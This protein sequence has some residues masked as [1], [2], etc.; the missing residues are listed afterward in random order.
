[1][2]VDRL[3]LALLAASITGIVWMAA[4]SPAPA[5]PPGGEVVVA[6]DTGCTLLAAPP[7]P[8]TP[9]CSTNG[10]APEAMQGPFGSLGDAAGGELDVKAMAGVAPFDELTVLRIGDGTPDL[11]SHDRL[12]LAIRVGGLWYTRDLASIGP[13]CGGMGHPT[14]VDAEA[15]AP[16]IVDGAVS[17]RVRETYRQ[18]DSERTADTLVECR[19]DP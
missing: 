2:L 11:S 8:P 1:M 3:D 16:R 7:R 18:G 6:P 17:V 13:F 19:L 14:W 4:R 12:A 15:A 5:G 9:T 10:G